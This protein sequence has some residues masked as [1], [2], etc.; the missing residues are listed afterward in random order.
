[1]DT[2][3]SKQIYEALYSDR[4]ANAMVFDLEK[5]RTAMFEEKS[6]IPGSQVDAEVLK[7]VRTSVQALLVML[8]SKYANLSMMIRP[9]SAL[10]S[11]EFRAGV[12]GIGEIEAPLQLYNR[13]VKPFLSA[14]LSNQTVQQVLVQ[15]RDLLKPIS[16]IVAGIQRALVGLVSGINQNGSTQASNPTLTF[17]FVRCVEALAI[18]VLM[19]EQLMSGKLAVITNDLIKPRIWDIINKNPKWQTIAG[20]KNVEKLFRDSYY[21]MEDDDVSATAVAPTM[22]TKP[23]RRTGKP[24]RRN[25][26][27]KIQ[28]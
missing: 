17:Y 6:Q 7:L 25:R 27:R 21:E 2:I 9:G 18:Y 14:R 26:K 16:R 22:P 11:Q 10:A 8:D 5:K 28:E 23:H 19:D 24:K 13:I 4:N 1:M 20:K 12:N 3:R 15:S